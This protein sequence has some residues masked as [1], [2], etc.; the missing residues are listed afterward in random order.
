MHTLIRTLKLEEHIHLLKVVELLIQN[1]FP[2]IFVIYIFRSN[3][4]SFFREKIISIM[5]AS[6]SILLK[7]KCNVSSLR[8]TGI[9]NAS[10]NVWFIHSTLSMTKI[11]YQCIVDVTP[12]VL[13]TLVSYYVLHQHSKF[14]PNIS[15]Y[16]TLRI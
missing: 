15:D 5:Y 8:T 12:P 3:N 6:G 7:I 10:T 16:F 9:Q 11:T 13:P 4:K 1:W 2:K 14:W